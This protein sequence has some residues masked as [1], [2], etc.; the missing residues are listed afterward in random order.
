MNQDDFEYRWRNTPE[1]Y[2]LFKRSHE[3]G[4][5]DDVVGQVCLMPALAS[6]IMM[7]VVDSDGTV[8]IKPSVQVTSKMFTLEEVLELTVLCF[9]EAYVAAGHI[10]P[11]SVDWFAFPPGARERAKANR[12]KI[13]SV[14]AIPPPGSVASSGTVGLD[15]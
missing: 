10:K 12:G 3:Q 7:V 5:P 6:A 9:E 2:V 11:D 8:S 14:Q 1:G 13:D 15:S 4:Q